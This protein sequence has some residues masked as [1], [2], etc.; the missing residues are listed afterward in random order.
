MY[1][2]CA[3]FIY[4]YTE[5]GPNECFIIFYIIGLLIC[6]ISEAAFYCLFGQDG[7]HFNFLMCYW[8]AKSLTMHH[9]LE[10]KLIFVYIKLICMKT[11]ILKS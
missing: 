10:A 7:S 6:I 11:F 2:K 1:K 3:Y 9:I 4:H 5:N 8:V